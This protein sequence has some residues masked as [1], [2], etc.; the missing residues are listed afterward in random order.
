MSCQPP[1]LCSPFPPSA[2]TLPLPHL[3]PLTLPHPP[4]FTL[5]SIIR[6]PPPHTIPHP[7]SSTSQSPSSPFLHLTLSLLH[8][9]P[10]TL[11][12][13]PSS[14]SY[15]PSSIFL[16]LTLSLLN[17]PPPHTLHPPPSSTSHS[18]SSTFLHPQKVLK[19]WQKEN[20]K[21]NL[22][23]HLSFFS[24][25]LHLPLLHLTH[26]LSTSST[27]RKSRN[28]SEKKRR[29]QFNLLISELSTMVASSNRKMD[30]STVL[31]A[32]IAF[33]KNQKGEPGVCEGGAGGAGVTV[34]RQVWGTAVRR[35][36]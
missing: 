33:L 21:N 9:P 20:K 4:P 10:H 15:S 28:L 16:H 11:P 25:P 19:T 27:P 6:L 32:T 17:L 30:K 5:H 7:P 2:S 34:K 23:N 1:L 36:V 22:V 18:P 8:L 3:P 13:S 12:P 26:S 14:T 29:D 31:K 35:E 24:H